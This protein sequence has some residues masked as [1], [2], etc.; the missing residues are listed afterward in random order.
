[1]SWWVCSLSVLLNW[2][3]P[4]AGMSSPGCAWPADPFWKTKDFTDCRWCPSVEQ[5]GAAP[6]P[7][8]SLCV[9]YPCWT[10]AM[11][12]CGTPTQA[13]TGRQWAE[14]WETRL[15]ESKPDKIC[16]FLCGSRSKKM[17][18][19]S[20]QFHTYYIEEFHMF[21][22]V[23]STPMCLSGSPTSCNVLSNDHHCP[24]QGTVFTNAWDT[25]WLY[26]NLVFWISS[27]HENP[28]E[29]PSKEH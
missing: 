25:C 28:Q 22:D 1:M 10:V 4:R 29:F 16:G 24:R 12:E 3:S 14:G 23:L 11:R 19:F 5:R 15:C 2:Q 9:K 7:H 17:L 18:F 13:T 21:C 6:V 26:S 27:S 8:F 20:L